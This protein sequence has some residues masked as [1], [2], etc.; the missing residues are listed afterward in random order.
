MGGAGCRA[1]I[2]Q[3][4]MPPPGTTA[5]G[6]GPLRWGPAPFAPRRRPLRWGPGPLATSRRP[7]RWGPAP[8]ATIRRPLRWGPGPLATSRR[9]LRWG[10]APLA[11]SRRP[12]RWGPA[13]LATGRRP[14]RWVRDPSRPVADPFAG[15][16]QPS[17]RSATGVSPGRSPGDPG[18][19]ALW[20]RL[21]LPPRL[22]SG[23]TATATA[24]SWPVRAA[25][26]PDGLRIRT[27]HAAPP[28]GDVAR[29][30][31]A[32]P[33]LATC[34]AAGWR[35]RALA[36]DARGVAGRR[37]RPAA[38]PGPAVSATRRP[39]VRFAHPGYGPTD[40]GGAPGPAGAQRSYCD[41]ASDSSVLACSRSIAGSTISAS[42]P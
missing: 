40:Y 12:L 31:E 19:G 21:R 6:H 4:A 30:S 42:A 33:G 27:V 10:P 8:L 20:L 1:P 37:M 22:P 28:A 34:P 5:T 35:H 13:P 17:G 15:L 16:Q 36:S 7:L 32:Y 18:G 3:A 26:P 39:R 14:L 11:T 29:V 2:S 25:S 24:A 9:P 38:S 41:S 23:R